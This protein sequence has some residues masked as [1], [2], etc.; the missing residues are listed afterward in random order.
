MK[1]LFILLSCFT[2]TFSFGQT[3]VLKYVNPMI[4]TGGHGHTFPGATLPFGM[5]QLSPDTRLNGWDGCSGYHDS[6]TIVYGFSHTHLSGTGVED[7]CD[8]LLMPTTGAVLNSNGADGG[9]GYRS[10]FNK[11]NEKATPN[12]YKTKLDASGTEV[13]LTATT[14]VGFH[15]YT[16]PEGTSEANVV[17]DL[18]HRDRVLES[19]LRIVNDYEVEGFRV[20]EAWAKK[21]Q[22]YFVARFS[23]P[24]FKRDNKDNIHT[25]GVSFLG[26]NRQLLVK[27]G[28]SA[29]ST[30][31]A[32]ANLD[33]EIPNWN[34]EEVKQNG[35]K[36]WRKALSQIEIEGGSV[37]Q[38]TMFYTALYHTFI[39]PNTYTDVDGKYRSMDGFV[40]NVLKDRTY[41]TVFSLWDTYR[42]A[43]PLY[44]ILCPD[45]VNDF[46][47]TFVDDYQKSGALSMWPL[48]GNETWCMIGNHSIP[49]I[50][51]AYQ[52]GIRKYNEYD[53]YEAIKGTLSSSRMGQQVYYERGYLP[54]ELESESVSK[55]LEFAYD[56]WC[57]AQLGKMLKQEWY[58]NWTAAQSYKNVLDPETGFMRA[59]I[60]ETWVRP[61]EPR[62]INSH[63]T[64]GNAW[65]YSF[66]VPHDIKGLYSAM[67]GKAVFEKKLD[68]LFAAT[69]ETTGRKQADV[70]GLIG[71][72]AHGNEP[73]HQISYLYNYINKPWKTQARVHE[74]LKTMYQ[75]AP[76][77][78]SGNEDCGQMSAW[79]IMSALGIYPVNPCGG[80][81]VITTPMFP[82]VT[83]HLP[84]GRNLVISAKGVSDNDFLIQKATWQGQNYP[85]SHISHFQ[86]LEGGE[87]AFQTSNKPSTTWGI[88]DADIP[89]T[90]MTNDLIV[91]LPFV[92]KGTRTFAESQ[93]ITLGHLTEGNK[94][95][96]AIN[97]PF[98]INEL[99]KNE[100]YYKPFE[101]K[102]TSN[103]SF[104]AVDA[105]GQQSAVV[106]ASFLKN[107]INRKISIKNKYA[108]MYSAEGDLSLVDGLR[109]W[110]NF[111]TGAWQGYDGVNL[112]VVIDLGAA[113]DIHKVGLS[114]LQD[115]N[116]WI[117]FPT[118]VQ[119]ETS[120]DGINFVALDLVKNTI[121]P[122]ESP[123]ILHTF[124]TNK[125]AKAR[126]VHVV[127][128]YL[129]RIPDWH[130]GKGYKGWIFA[131]EVIV[132]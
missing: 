122:A 99:D 130:K 115:Q 109:G 13:E 37:D 12:Y 102:E 23:E 126:Y 59:K 82:K 88:A 33:A 73:S 26:K 54:A 75:N 70:T 66:Y 39:V 57:V 87:L 127:A 120:T 9:L 85:K 74:I 24:I 132:E 7:Y 51:D 34:F 53:A 107:N 119:Y 4:G 114:C 123:T 20:S 16:Y 84:N 69:S 97:K 110:A 96:Y 14:R 131:D 113:Q 80:D 90:S 36:I 3:D 32:R 104:M 2:L 50:V 43:H 27:V 29:V 40:S 1:Y 15:R 128:T 67:G 45:R 121:D 30:D 35:E 6:D 17:I 8:I 95:Y 62:E 5:V 25:F 124:E 129:D 11:K 58:S 78:L 81:Y 98:N 48:A 68:D 19:D 103:I 83:I 61:F 71:Q 79:F 47:Y 64:E 31:G 111:H 93:N 21:Q 101:I 92:S 49:V 22:V 72:Y 55:T 117:F 118:S 91:P 86:L 18:A 46:V 60:N 42:A 106:S 100:L 112:D 89:E 108:K 116:S 56:D 105:E 77:G 94:I 76:D 28:I 65:Q 38:K 63:Y 44:T 10:V 125:T 41:Y 52:K